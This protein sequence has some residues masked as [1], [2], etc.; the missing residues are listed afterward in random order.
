[1]MND[2][3]MPA[4][5][6]S[7]LIGVSFCGFGLIVVNEWSARVGGAGRARPARPG[8]APGLVIGAYLNVL[9]DFMRLYR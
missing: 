6:R 3:T 9:N 2:I 4:G 7:A 5:E 8:G 1:M